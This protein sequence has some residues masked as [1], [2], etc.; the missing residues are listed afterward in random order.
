MTSVGKTRPYA[1]DQHKDAQKIR[2]DL[3][4]GTEITSIMNKYG[5][6][7]RALVNYKKNVLGKVAI[8]AVEKR[9]LVDAEE[10]FNIILS[11]VRY[12]EKLAASC[13][14][15]LQDPDEPEMYFMGARAHNID[16]VWEDVIP[17]ESG[18]KF[19]KHRDKLQEII[20][21]NMPKDAQILSIR[22]TKTDNSVLLVKSAE[23]LTK[24]MDSLV[25]AWRTIDQGKS[26][27]LGTPAWNQVVR[28][29]L[30]STAEYP[31][32][33]RKISDGLSSITI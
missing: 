11:T 27:F 25:Q 5:I 8:K 16:V 33:R 30:D 32:I 4:E 14:R 24:Q 18:V 7:H 20:D 15:E 12:M 31:E 13:D 6:S 26:S 21:K 2:V 1:V 29:I 28:V 23:M 22:V 17:V 3:A 19:I 10:L 9:N